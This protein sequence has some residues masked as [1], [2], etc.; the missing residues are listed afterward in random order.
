LSREDETALCSIIEPNP[1]SP[2]DSL[3]ITVLL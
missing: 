2:R 3:E 1:L